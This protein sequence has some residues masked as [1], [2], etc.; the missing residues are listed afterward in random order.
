[1]TNEPTPL[2]KERARTREQNILHPFATSPFELATKKKKTMSR[3]TTFAKEFPV[4]I[5]QWREDLLCDVD[6]A[7]GYPGLFT[8]VAAK[9]RLEGQ[10][11]NR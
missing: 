7:N 4:S 3:L 11:F 6:G 5:F 8:E 2:S 9:L 1:M 10:T